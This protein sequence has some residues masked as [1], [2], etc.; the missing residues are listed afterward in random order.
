MFDSISNTPDTMHNEA[1]N[2]T[3]PNT[4]QRIC[5]CPAIIFCFLFFM[6]RGFKFDLSFSKVIYVVVHKGIK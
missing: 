6:A 1:Q 3:A 4:H 5:F 2:E